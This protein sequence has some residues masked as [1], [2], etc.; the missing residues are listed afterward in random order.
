MNPTNVD[1]L[2][3]EYNQGARHQQDLLQS[4]L[5]VCR[6]IAAG[7][8]GS[9]PHLLKTLVTPINSVPNDACETIKSQL[10][11]VLTGMA[12]DKYKPNAEPINIAG[13]LCARDYKGPNNYGFN[14]VIEN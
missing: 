7:V 5:G 3:G 11:V 1:T 6:T 13:A 12:S 10:P 9:A 14:A 8:H 4:D 2:V